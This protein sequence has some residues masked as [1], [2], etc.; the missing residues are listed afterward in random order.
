LELELKRRRPLLALISA[1]L[2]VLVALAFI[3]PHLMVSPG[4][5]KR[6]HTELTQD[7]FACHQPWRGA[8]SERCVTCHAVQDIGLRTTKGI[9]V[10]HKIPKTPFHQELVEQ[11]CVACHSGHQRPKLTHR[12]L[13]PFSHALLR[14]VVSDRCEGCHKGPSDNLHRQNQSNCKTCHV[15][16]HWKPTTFAHDKGFVLDRDHDTKC[17]TCHTNDDYSRYTC[18]GCHEHTLEKMRKKHVKEGIADF[19][20]CVS[21]HR[22]ARDEPKREGSHEGR[23]RH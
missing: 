15:Q 18:Y 9:P 21:C 5:L 17:A 8:V 6:G 22:S 20:N 2:L 11:D 12:R 1:N 16:D 3:Y 14:P 10:T 23:K 7:C 19:E 13:K 4:A